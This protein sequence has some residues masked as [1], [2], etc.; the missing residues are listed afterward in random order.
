MK[1]AIIFQLLLA[2]LICSHVHAQQS[3][4]SAKPKTTATTQPKVK[5]PENSRFRDSLLIIKKPVK[6]N[7]QQQSAT[8]STKAANNTKLDDLKNPFDTLK[9][10][11]VKT[12]RGG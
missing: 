10:P 5:Q 4:K 8:Q 12:K 9:S 11:K 1:K 7:N 3:R 2:T 6:A